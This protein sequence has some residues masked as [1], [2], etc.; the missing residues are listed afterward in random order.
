MNRGQSS[1]KKKR[2]RKSSPKRGAHKLTPAKRAARARL[3]KA[4]EDLTDR[5]AANVELAY[6]PI[7]TSWSREEPFNRV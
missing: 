4:D 2:P 3:F 5:I 7:D 1:A 6:E